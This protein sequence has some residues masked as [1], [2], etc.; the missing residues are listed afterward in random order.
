MS[1]QELTPPAP[2]GEFVLF[3]SADG[4]V[5]VECRFEADT[6]WLSQ[7]QMGSLY[8]KAKAT[9]S[10]HI[11]KV[12]AEGE[13]EEESVVRFYRTTVEKAKIKT[14]LSSCGCVQINSE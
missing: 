10:E 11:A 6:L 1:D 13:C 5:R 8:G 12:F 4:S 2:G 7:A 14:G 9:I 3:Q